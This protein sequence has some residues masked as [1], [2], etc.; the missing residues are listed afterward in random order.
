MTSPQILLISTILYFTMLIVLQNNKVLILDTY[1]SKMVIRHRS[2]VCSFIFKHIDK[3]FGLIIL[4]IL[5]IILIRI[6]MIGMNNHI[7]FK[8]GILYPSFLVTIPWLITLSVSSIFKKII[9]RA[10]PYILPIKRYSKNSYSFPSI[11][12]ASSLSIVFG[13]ILYFGKLYALLEQP[14]IIHHFLIIITSLFISHF[15]LC[16][17]RIYLG[18]HYLSDV[19]GGNLIAVIVYSFLISIG[20]FNILN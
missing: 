13:I 1:V 4:G 15:L 10:R 11:H 9:K 20:Y 18:V 14:T 17:S 5:F 2:M 7:L 3:L 12:A 16:F 8:F 6:Q 19:V